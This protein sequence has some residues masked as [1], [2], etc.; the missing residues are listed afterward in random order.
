MNL[1]V[2]NYPMSNPWCTVDIAIM[3]QTPNTDYTQTVCVPPGIVA[4]AASPNSGFELGTAPWHDTDGDPGTGDPGTRNGNSSGTF[5]TVVA[6]TPKCVWVC[7]PFAS[8]G[9]GCPTTDQC[10][11]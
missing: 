4:V 6:G 7:C 8:N 5:V 11:H 1:T 3:G 10:A 9:T 2:L